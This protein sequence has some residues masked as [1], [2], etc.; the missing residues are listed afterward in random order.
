VDIRLRGS[1]SRRGS[2]RRSWG[3]LAGREPSLARRDLNTIELFATSLLSFEKRVYL[4]VHNLDLV[5]DLIGLKGR[6][7]DLKGVLVVALEEVGRGGLVLVPLRVATFP[8]GVV[9]E[10][11]A[12]A[13]A[14]NRSRE[15]ST[16]GKS[17]LVIAVPNDLSLLEVLPDDG[18]DTEEV[19]G[20]VAE[21]AVALRTRLGLPL[22]GVLCYSSRS[23]V[24]IR[25]GILLR[26]DG[27]G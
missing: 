23:R 11:F 25:P 9:V 16:I 10:T 5:V 12:H 8:V 15:E 17:D 1:G 27:R 2:G 22:G 19:V 26:R 20:S 6:D 7:L 3:L 18:T 24:T 13:T 14:R 21:H 4:C